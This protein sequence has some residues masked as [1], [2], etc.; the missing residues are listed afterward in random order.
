MA[1]RIP[2][3]ITTTSFYFYRK[4]VED[5]H[6]GE[7]PISIA[8]SQSGYAYREYPDLF[9]SWELIMGLKNG[10]IKKN[11]YKNK[12]YEEVLD[13]LNPDKVAED[14]RGCVLL[15][16]EKSNEFGHRKLVREWLTEHGHRCEE[17][18]IMVGKEKLKA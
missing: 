17:I 10:T 6:N 12:Y 8:R 14:L 2:V 13:K 9:P 1:K 16:Y 3:E 15:S 5:L 18:V 11:E 7:I 4:E